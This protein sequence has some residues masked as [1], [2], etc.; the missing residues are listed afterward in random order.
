MG[1]LAS[2]VYKPKDALPPDAGYNR[3]P[4]KTA[5]LRAGYG[6]EGDAK[7]GGNRHLNIMSAETLAALAGEGFQAEPGQMGEQ[8]ILTGIE[9]DALP[10]GTRLRLGEQACVEFT[11][12]RTGCSKLE[13]HQG[14]LRAEAARRLGTMARVVTGGDIKIGDSV[15]VVSEG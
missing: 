8:L 15:T 2:I 3:I 4:L 6:I 11:E 10:P 5:R 1:K 14:K 12:P 9:V 13:R 7:G